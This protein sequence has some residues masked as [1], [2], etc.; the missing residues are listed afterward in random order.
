MRNKKIL[1]VDDDMDLVI[2][3]KAILENE[4]YTIVTASN[5][6]EG[7][8]K[9]QVE[10]P[11]LAIL[12][13]MMEGHHDGFDL[14]RKIKKAKE[15]KNTPILMLT[16]IS[17][18]TGVNFRAASADPEWLPADEYIDKPVEPEVLVEEVAKLLI[19]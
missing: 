4:N 17:D 1:I 14:A 3:L 6:N 13:V 15:F 5:Q 18:V 9:M 11:D 7:W 8:E 19:I 16:S 12:D 2:A 10:K